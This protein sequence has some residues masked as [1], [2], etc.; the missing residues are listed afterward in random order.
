MTTA[1]LS[2]ALW[3][4]PLNTASLHREHCVSM[5]APRRCLA[6]GPRLLC[7][8]LLRGR[9]PHSWAMPNAACG[10][11]SE[12]PFHCQILVPALSR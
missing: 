10:I 7:M 3:L 11:A 12:L 5:C 8:R 9:R 2:C 4:P 6:L 1:I